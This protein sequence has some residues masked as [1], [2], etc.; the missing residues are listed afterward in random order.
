MSRAY[1]I[2]IKQS[3]RHVL[4]ASDHVSTKLELLEILPPERM[5]DLLANELAKRGFKMQGEKLTRETKD[6]VIIEIDPLQATV[7]VRAE[8]KQTV[9]IEGERQ[10]WSERPPEG[11]QQEHERDKLRQQLL[12]DLQRQAAEQK[13]Q[14]QKSVTDRLEGHLMDLRKELDA[15]VNRVTADALKEKAAQMGQ[16]K[17]LTE[18]ETGS[19]TIVL[20]V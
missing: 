9:T 7:M 4:R 11:K 18:D 2:K 19:L 8:T 16:I 10:T 13:A 6:G 20:E 5:A 14:L 15:A 1:K 17:S 12:D 3:A